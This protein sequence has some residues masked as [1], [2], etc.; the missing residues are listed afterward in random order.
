MEI[1]LISKEKDRKRNLVRL[2]DSKDD[3]MVLAP[4][5]KVVIFYVRLI[6]I[7]VRRSGLEFIPG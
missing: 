3:K 5:I 4:L 2:G 7:D 6:K 1:N